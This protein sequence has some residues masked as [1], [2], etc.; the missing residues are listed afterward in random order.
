LRAELTALRTEFDAFKA[1]AKPVIDG[2]QPGPPQ[3]AWFKP[4]GGSPLRPSPSPVP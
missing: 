2:H 1:Y 3:P 4:M